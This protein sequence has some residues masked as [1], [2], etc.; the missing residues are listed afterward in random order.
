MLKVL[1]DLL[2]RKSHSSESLG[3]P[4]ITQDVSCQQKELGNSRICF[5]VECVLHKSCDLRTR[6]PVLQL[7][8][9]CWLEVS[10]FQLSRD[11][12]H[13]VRLAI[14]GPSLSA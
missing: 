8:E 7:I 5:P 6:V 4:R 3:V 2:I 13:T 1:Q 11:N 9:A 12:R 14:V 10:R